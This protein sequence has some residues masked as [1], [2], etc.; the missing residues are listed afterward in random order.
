MINYVEAEL[1][2]YRWVEVYYDLS[3][4]TKDEDTYF[5]PIVVMSILLQVRALSLGNIILIP[6]LNCWVI[7]LSRM[8]NTEV[9]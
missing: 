6:I 5:Y 9:I 2:T 8:E 7:L 3:A 4:Q 1:G